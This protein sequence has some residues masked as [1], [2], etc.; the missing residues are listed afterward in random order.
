[1]RGLAEM[2][3]MPERSFRCGPLALQ[4][5]LS[6]AKSPPSPDSLM[7]LEDSRSTPNGLSLTSVQ[8]A[9]V[10]AGMNFRMALRAP[11]AQ[12]VTP[13]VVHWKVGH[14]AA[15]LGNNADG[16]YQVEDATFGQAVRISPDTLDAQA[17]G[18]VLV[19]P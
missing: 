7:A 3:T 18:D 9:S 1:M 12:I 2:L 4:R 11:G 13:A 16:R 5:I 8:A 15:V 6:I 19:P 14:Y 17:S 10:R